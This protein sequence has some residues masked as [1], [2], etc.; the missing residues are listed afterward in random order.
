MVQRLDSKPRPGVP[1]TARYR[2]VIGCVLLLLVACGRN[3]RA[4]STAQTSGS[5]QVSDDRVLNVDN[6]AEYIAP[7]TIRNFEK[8]SGIKVNYDVYSSSEALETKLLTG[9]SGYDVVVA[10]STTLERGVKAGAFRP[11]DK[12]KLSNYGELDRTILNMLAVN[13]SG[14]LY[15]IPY[16]WSTTGFGYN[17]KAVHDAIGDAPVNSWGLLFNPK[18]AA[19][20][21]HCGLIILDSPEDVFDAVLLFLGL[22]PAN[23]NLAELDLAAAALQKVRSYIRN[24]Q[25]IAVSELA[26]GEICVAMGWSGDILQARQLAKRSRGD[27]Q[28]HYVIPTEGSSLLLDVMAVPAD[29]PHPD[30]ALTFLNYMLRPEVAAAITN[31][32]LYASSN[33]GAAKLID[34]GIRA[35]QDIY[36]PA[37][38][39]A[40]LV[41]RRA[42]SLEYSRKE[43][44]LWAKFRT[45]E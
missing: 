14:N 2:A 10:A 36:P 19:K 21:Q 39:M 29:A 17:T 43:T 3:E 1:V 12:S 31:Y 38:V 33:A 27:I 30:N 13:D 6:W 7:D 28:L 5:G 34:P 18:Y 4:A 44:R 11:L 24:F 37:D 16:L 45:G 23:D 9:H 40:R 20:L 22:N 42:R 8:E 41:P 35:D 25:N 32:R 15:A 26:N